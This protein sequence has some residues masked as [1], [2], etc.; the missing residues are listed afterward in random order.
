M[1]VLNRYS[2][3]ETIGDSGSRTRPVTIDAEGTPDPI[4]P[5]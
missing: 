2:L 3:D 4:R 5:V 1:Q